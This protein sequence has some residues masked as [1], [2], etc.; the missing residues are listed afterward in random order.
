MELCCMA[1]DLARDKIRTYLSREVPIGVG[2]PKQPR[3]APEAVSSWAAGGLLLP[4]LEC[5]VL[6]KALS[7]SGT[8]PGMWSRPAL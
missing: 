5:G 1:C 8:S 7:S 4:I 6:P 2:R 3:E